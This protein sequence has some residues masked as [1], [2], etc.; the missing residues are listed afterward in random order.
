MVEKYDSTDFWYAFI[1]SLDNRGLS[2][3]KG[4]LKID[5]EVQEKL[6]VYLKEK[7]EEGV[8]NGETALPPGLHNYLWRFQEDMLPKL[9]ALA[10]GFLK[11]DPNH[12]AASILLTILERSDWNS[13]DRSLMENTIVLMPKDPCMNLTVIDEYRK[14]HGYFGVL[15]KQGEI[16]SALEN[17]YAWAKQQDDTARYQEAKSFYWG[18]RITPYSVY[19]HIKD[20]I[21]QW[22]GIV[23]DG[24]L[25]NARHRDLI[26]KCRNLIPEEQA[27]FQRNLVQESDDQQKL[28]DAP[29]E[30]T[31]FWNAYLDTLENRGLSTR[32]WKLSQR[33]QEQLLTYFKT[34]IEEDVANGKTALPLQLPEYISHFPETMCM[35]LRE[36]AEEVLETQPE[37]GAA[38][39]ILAIIVWEGK[40]IH[41]GEK[42]VDLLL[43]EQA[44][45]LTH[46]DPETCFFAISHY[47]I[48]LD[49]LYELTLTALE[50]LFESAKKQDDSELYQWLVKIYNEVGITPCNIYRIMMK[51]PQENA[52]LINRCKPLLT[53]MQHAFEHRLSHEPD[54]W[55]ALRGLGDVYEA[56]GETKLAHKYPWQPHP[57]FRWKQPAW[58]GKFLPDFSSATLDGTPVSFSD[59]QGKLMLL[60]FSAKWCGFC[61]P[62]IPYIKETYETHYKDGFDVIGVSVDENKAD[63]REFIQEHEIPWQQLFDEKGGKRD[64]AHHFGITKVPSQ[65]LIDRDGKIISVD[66]RKEQLG[67]LVKWTESTRVGNVVPEFSAVDV[68][69]KQV[70]FSDFRG[71]VVL[72][73]FCSSYCKQELTFI[74]AVYRLYHKKGF[75][76]IGVNV[77][78]WKNSDAFRDLVHRE[79]HQGC[80]IYADDGMN[81]E[82]KKQ[83]GFGDSKR[84]PGIVMIDK[85]GRVIEA[86]CGRVYS[87]EIWASRLEKLVEVHLQ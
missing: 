29:S 32:T 56:S 59:Y 1:N 76:V 27:A 10:E 42:D 82:L 52:E 53:D 68:D 20:G 62:E 74:K 84:L 46:P 35:E 24:K 75:E 57:E 71:K 19:K 69:G 51:S 60:N 37:N 54:D 4:E 39:K 86:R 26:K 73:Y 8:S 45:T 70:S 14:S 13:K 6:L 72:L 21:R 22:T 25:Y 67:Q 23:E 28:L 15:N 55:Y 16:L 44:M 77:A 79:N 34:K 50:R 30:N 3:G 18:H 38:A 80:Y 5:E 43:L 58:V 49:P 85:A 65:W 12:G 7:I 36:F 78:G 83:F 87:P 48:H 81:G 66:T 9:Q 2:F 47:T 33:I 63:L 31:D 61:A 11:S 17:L 40:H 64:L 41:G